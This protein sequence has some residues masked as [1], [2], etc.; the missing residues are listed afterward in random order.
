MGLVS[1]NIFITSGFPEWLRR[2]T[3]FQSRNVGICSVVGPKITTA[4]I[5]AVGQNALR[6]KFTT[7]EIPAV[8]QNALRPSDSKLTSRTINIQHL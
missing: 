5:R 8:A 6:P 4:R 1:P 7:A 2:P 3:E